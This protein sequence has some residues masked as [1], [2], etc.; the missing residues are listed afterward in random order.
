MPHIDGGSL[1]H[2]ALPRHKG[3]GGKIL[4]VFHHT[5]LI[6]GQAHF[7]QQFVGTDL[8]DEADAH[9]N[10]WGAEHGQKTREVSRPRR[11]EGITGHSSSF[12]PVMDI[13]PATT[14]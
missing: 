13:T 9:G 6:D 11:V 4:L 2:N 14:P 1:H 10:S 5:P 12:S 8:M 7:G 3:Q